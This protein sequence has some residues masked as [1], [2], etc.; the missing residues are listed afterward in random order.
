MCE[1]R[2]LIPA[3]SGD[4]REIGGRFPRERRERGTPGVGGDA[5]PRWRLGGPAGRAAERSSV[6]QW[7]GGMQDQ[8]TTYVKQIFAEEKGMK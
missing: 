8:T 1:R 5:E 2:G 3:E 6:D 4:G 7:N